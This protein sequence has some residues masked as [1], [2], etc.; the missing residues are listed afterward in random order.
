MLRAIN[1]EKIFH[2]G[3]R[4]DLHV[5]NDINFGL[6]KA[7]TSAIIGSSG[8]GKT[9]IAHALVERLDG[10]HEELYRFIFLTLGLLTATCPCGLWLGRAD[11]VVVVDELVAAGDQ[12]VRGRLLDTYADHSFVV[13]FELVDQRR[14][15]AV[16]REQRK[17][18]DVVF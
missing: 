1:I 8:S 6:D 17:G 12:Q 14:E 7:E 16:A 11:Q 4:D 13:F 18:V 10:L 15:V 9:T 2:D 3:I 5:L